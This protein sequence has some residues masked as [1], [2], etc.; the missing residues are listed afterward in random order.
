VQPADVRRG[1]PI[2]K[3]TQPLSLV[4][5]I[6]PLPLH[7]SLLHLGII[8]PPQEDRRRQSTC[9]N[10][11]SRIITSTPGFWVRHTVIE[12]LRRLDKLSR[13]RIG[14]L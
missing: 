13:D 5:R 10:K 3:I 14:H 11:Q 9:T 12:C 6:V 1:Q 4:C 2:L 7:I 8:L